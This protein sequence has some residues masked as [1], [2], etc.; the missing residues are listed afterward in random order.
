MTEPK[1]SFNGIFDEGFRTALH[2]FREARGLTY[3][4]L[5]FRLNCNWS[6][7]CKWEKGKSTKCSGILYFA[8]KRLFDGEFDDWLQMDEQDQKDRMI[9]CIKEIRNQRFKN[10]RYYLLRRTI[11]GRRP[12]PVKKPNPLPFSGVLTPLHLQRLLWLQ[13][14]A[15]L[16]DELFSQIIGCTQITLRNWKKGRST[17]CQKRFIVALR[18]LLRGEL[19]DNFIALQQLI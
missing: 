4:E 9:A 2:D 11:K 16:S 12:I 8:L 5:A 14:T 18:L 3:Q 17:C 1:R 6:T 7:I 19:D 15:R 10:G 13:S